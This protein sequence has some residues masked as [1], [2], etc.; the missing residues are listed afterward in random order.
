MKIT[1]DDN[2]TIQGAHINAQEDNSEI[3]I[4]K[5][6]MLSN[7]IVIRTSDSHPIYD[8]STKKRLNSAKSVYIEDHV[9]IAAHAS[10]L[11]GC[12]IGAGAIIGLGSVVTRNIPESTIAGGN[13][14]KVLKENVYWNHS[15]NLVEPEFK[16]NN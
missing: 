12:K 11:K 14:A 4:G 10:I 15:L 5:C 8:K 16:N 3:Y 7:N 2:T 13:P 6:C 9:W 1:I